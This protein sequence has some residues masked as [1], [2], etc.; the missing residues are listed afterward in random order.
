MV[1]DAE[2]FAALAVRGSDSDGIEIE[3]TADLTTDQ[4]FA[5]DL[6][7]HVRTKAGEKKYGQPIG[8]VIV[9]DPV[10][11]ADKVRRA[12]EGPLTAESVE[13]QAE[14]VKAEFRESHPD[15]KIDWADLKPG[16][17]IPD[18]SAKS[19]AQ[20]LDSAPLGTT[21][22]IEQAG[23]R[24]IFTK[25]PGHW[26]SR[27][28]AGN[29]D[30]ATNG[31]DLVSEFGWGDTK[32]RLPP[33]FGGDIDKVLHPKDGDQ[34]TYQNTFDADAPTVTLTFDAYDGTFR[35][36][37][38]SLAYAYTPNQIQ[39]QI[40]TASAHIHLGPEGDR[41]AI[42]KYLFW[43]A[44]ADRLDEKFRDGVV[45]MEEIRRTG[46]TKVN[47]IALPRGWSQVTPR[48]AFADDVEDAVAYYDRFKTSPSLRLFKG[49][50]G[51]IAV[52][53]ET[54]KA[55]FL[56]QFLDG[57]RDALDIAATAPAIKDPS[58]QAVRRDSSM[59]AN[60]QVRSPHM[61]FTVGRA[62]RWPEG[63]ALAFV[64]N[65]LP[66]DVQVNP[67][68]LNGTFDGGDSSV[69]AITPAVRPWQSMLHRLTSFSAYYDW[70]A[71][72]AQ[73]M[74]D[75][76]ETKPEQNWW[77]PATGL[78]SGDNIFTAALVHELG[79]V[80]DGR[81]HDTSGGSFD[82]DPK[83]VDFWRDHSGLSQYAATNAAEGYAEAF[84]EWFF[85]QH[86]TP[87]QRKWLPA[88]VRKIA[89]AYAVEYGWGEPPTKESR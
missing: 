1:S 59:P 48:E 71:D 52:V 14:R 5:I 79:H 87:D 28:P 42:E 23:A 6:V 70:K 34:I 44:D 40:I 56:P 4:A 77:T 9:R 39:Q 20:W 88:Q 66:D 83:A 49:K 12:T 55:K 21:I 63:S 13:A 74:A 46:A 58:A 85:E 68:L 29:T 17:T 36:G 41:A 30:W 32:F 22:E 50:H 78:G 24:R 53:D 26:T 60:F 57:V 15:A 61:T 47:P 54:A 81:H 72:V 27:N 3:E 10:N 82:A 8:S 65:N 38:K 19:R 33:A 84:A 16:D 69:H 11:I 75:S 18:T 51:E 86:L 80:N 43:Q 62:D 64:R 89:A 37:K 35:Q 45:D 76:S 7:R 25:A 67:G 73:G 2:G 31:A